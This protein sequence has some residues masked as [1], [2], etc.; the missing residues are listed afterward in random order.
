MYH[1]YVFV[2]EVNIMSVLKL[3][4]MEGQWSFQGLP[5]SSSQNLIYSS[6]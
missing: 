2:K 6:F 1:S 4:F 5:V 3:R